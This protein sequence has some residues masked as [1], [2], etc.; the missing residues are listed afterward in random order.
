MKP[1]LASLHAV[2]RIARAAGA[3]ILDVYRR[4]FDAASKADG[5]PVTAADRIAEA[6]IVPALREL[7]AALPVVAEEAFARGEVPVVGA[8]FWLVDPLDGTREFVARND[9]FTVNIALVEDRAPR[10]GVVYAPA[11]QRLFSG[12]VGEGA[13]QV[14]GGARPVVRTPL[15]VRALPREGATVA[16]SRSHLSA[17]T[18]EWLRGRRV[19]ARVQVGSSLKFGL[20]AAG[21]ADWYPRRGR[22]ME[23]DTAA[24]H[25]VLRAAGGDV[26]TLD[27]EPLRYAKPG[28]ENP[29]FFAFGSCGLGKPGAPGA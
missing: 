12:L 19:A 21:E 2:E 26:C 28:F 13:W 6:H 3:L 14:R 20:L 16:L 7:D 22:T 10:L 15:A 29:D 24:G 4:P 25:A 8:R 1:D 17:A 23:W 5:S 18:R 9:E 27:G 11:L